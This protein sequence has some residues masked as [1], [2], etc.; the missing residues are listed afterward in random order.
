M[1][2]C[3]TTSK[4]RALRLDFRSP[5]VYASERDPQA[6]RQRYMQQTWT[7]KTCAICARPRVDLH[8]ARYEGIP[9][10]LGFVF[11]VPLCRFHH[12]DFSLN[13]WPRLRKWMTRAD[14]TL[15][16]VTH[17]DRLHW[18]LDPVKDGERPHIGVAPEQMA[19]ELWSP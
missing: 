7:R 3:L 5:T 17:G 14:A 16:Y 2:R 4:S 1:N 10:G 13:V 9:P 12:E 6:Q 18:W 19:L 11:L 15:A 8:H